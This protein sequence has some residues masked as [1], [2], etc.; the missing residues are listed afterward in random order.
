MTKR[1]AKC[2]FP[3]TF[4]GIEFDEAG[5]CNFCRDFRGHQFVEQSKRQYRKRFEELIDKNRRVGGY[6][7]L[8]AYSGGK[9]SSYTLVVLKKK[10]NLSILALTIDNGFI[11]PVATR[12]ILNVVESDTIISHYTDNDDGYGNSVEV[13]ATAVTDCSSPIVSDVRSSMVTRSG[14]VVTYKTS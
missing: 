2:V 13:D 10:Y 12:N 7:C 14:A 8:M 3:E 9:D 5:V 6:D 11:S 4:P 1:C